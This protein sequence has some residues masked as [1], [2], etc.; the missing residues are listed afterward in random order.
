M[1]GFGSVGYGIIGASGSYSTW[2]GQSGS[3]GTFITKG[4]AYGLGGSFGFDATV[5][6]S[7][8]AFGGRSRGGCVALLVS[9]C[10]G[11]NS[12]GTTVTLGFG[13][14][15]GAVYTDTRTFLTPVISSCRPPDGTAR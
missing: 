12:S 5:K 2:N 3:Y 14:S 11:V 7:T 4:K 10:I 13:L 8:G 6:A 1:S 15:V 9:L